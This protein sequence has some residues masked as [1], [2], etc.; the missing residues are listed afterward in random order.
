MRPSTRGRGLSSLVLV[1]LLTAA[2]LASCG[3]AV[4]V[5][6]PPSLEE[7]PEEVGPSTD[8]PLEVAP[9]GRPISPFTGLAVDPAV[10]ER[11][12]LV[13]K[14][15]NSPASR[16][17]SGLD[18]ADIV[19]EE[20]VE[21][22]ITRFFVLFHSELPSAA[23]P[24]RSARP[25]D[26][27]LLKGLGPSGFAFS[28]ARREVQDLLATTPSIRI[29]EGAAGFF[30][31][32]RRNAPHNLYLDAAR[33]L[34]AVEGRGALPLTGI[35]WTF[36]AEVPEGGLACPA[37]EAGCTDAGRR[38]VVRMSA[39]YLSGWTYEDT[40]GRYRR[41][42]N[43][44]DFEVTGGGRVGAANVVILST[45]HYTGVSGYPETDVVTGPQPRPA[46][47]LRDGRRY[48]ARWSKPTEGSLLVLT[49]PDGTPFPLKPGPTWV[50]LPPPEAVTTLLP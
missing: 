15:E 28:G 33:T 16:P 49:T 42:Q 27:Q 37:D 25:V 30:R 19:Y 14:I 41:D 23:G 38:V 3:R 13:V 43:G 47:V 20:V 48:E 34:E 45:R 18:A 11:A 21:G 32:D 5:A 39:G 10:T 24:V 2:V 50:H 35:G 6:G 1:P 9:D 46:V 7:A 22:G 26:T 29:T 4:E 36:D 40:T 17:Q 44:R 31:D 8:A 12:L